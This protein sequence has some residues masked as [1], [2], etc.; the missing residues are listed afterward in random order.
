MEVSGEVVPAGE[1]L[2]ALRAVEKTY[3]T[4]DL[5]VGPEALR[6]AKTL[7]ALRASVRP[8]AQVLLLVALEVT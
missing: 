8:N 1:G 4:M 2:A 7:G 5:Q 6:P 3:P